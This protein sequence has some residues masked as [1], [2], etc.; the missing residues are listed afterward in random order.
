[1]ENPA[2]IISEPKIIGIMRIPRICREQDK[3]SKRVLMQLP[4]L[5]PGFSVAVDYPD[6]EEMK[7]GRKRI[8]TYGIQLYGAGRLTTRSI[9]NRLFVW[10]KDGIQEIDFKIRDLEAEAENA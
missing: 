10:I 1:M 5:Q 6:F 8:L 3:I 4:D 2:V 7:A 9:D